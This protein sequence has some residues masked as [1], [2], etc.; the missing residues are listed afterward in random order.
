MTLTQPYAFDMPAADAPVVK[1]FDGVATLAD[2]T[3]VKTFHRYVARLGDVY[4][5]PKG[6]WKKPLVITRE[7]FDHWLAESNRALEKGRPIKATKALPNGEHSDHKDPQ[8]TAGDVVRF[9]EENIDGG[10]WL[11]AE[12][13]ARGQE[14]IDLLERN[15]DVS[16][17]TEPYEKDSQGNEFQDFIRAVCVV[18]RPVVHSQPLAASRDEESLTVLVR[19]NAKTF[20]REAPMSKLSAHVAKVCGIGEEDEDKLIGGIS[21][22]LKA[23]EA[24]QVLEKEHTDTKGKLASLE[25]EFAAHKEKSAKCSCG[26]FGKKLSRDIGSEVKGGRALINAAFKGGEITP[27]IRDE[28]LAE[29][30]GAKMLSRDTAPDVEALEAQ[31]ARLAKNKPV[32]AGSGT[33]AQEGKVLSR[34]V[35]GAEAKAADGNPWTRDLPEFQPKPAAK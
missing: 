19:Q 32:A 16:P 3:P 15:K 20:S 10:T 11:A 31:L 18:T 22:K 12:I 14:S 24:H 17:E 6:I 33:G 7:Q 4:D 29:W 27:V 13:Q 30:D 25:T 5:H 1:S 23:L 34:E 28:L 2:G 8:Y 21:E 26:A 35:P 9:V